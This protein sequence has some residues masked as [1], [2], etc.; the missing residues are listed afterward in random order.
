MEENNENIL[1]LKTLDS[2]SYKRV[3]HYISTGELERIKTPHGVAVDTL[4]LQKILGTETRGRKPTTTGYAIDLTTNS[5]INCLYRR[6]ATMN[7]YNKEMCQKDNRLTRYVNQDGYMCIN[8]KEYL[9]PQIKLIAKK[10]EIREY[11]VFDA[12]YDLLHKLYLEEKG[13]E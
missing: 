3:Y 6:V 1:I 12:I 10:L 8:L 9:K 7:K 2:K 11:K 4:K 13:I 5:K